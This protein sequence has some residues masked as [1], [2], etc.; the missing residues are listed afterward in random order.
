M[1]A[2][3]ATPSGMQVWRRF[4]H[5][6]GWLSLLA[7]LALLS[8]GVVIEANAAAPSAALHSDVSGR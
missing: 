4:A 6:L 1:V 7:T 5:A 3:S 8:P 2:L